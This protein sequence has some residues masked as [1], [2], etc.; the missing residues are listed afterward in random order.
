M[1]ASEIITSVAEVIKQAVE[2]TPAI[3]K[4]VDDA[5]PF[6]EIIWNNIGGTTVVSQ[7]D[8]DRIRIQI[9]AL[10][11][12]LQAPLPPEQPDDV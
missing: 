5:K 9:A 11:A 7:A 1:K 10:S 3:I 12:Q 8:L 6:A 4:T 2:L